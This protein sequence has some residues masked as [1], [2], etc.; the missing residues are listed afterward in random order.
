[1][2]MDSNHRCLFEILIYSQVPSVAR[3]TIQKT[4]IYKQK[5]P[6]H[7]SVPSGLP[8]LLG[9]FERSY[10]NDRSRMAS[11]DLSSKRA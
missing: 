5:S 8:V 7:L 3:P 2:V 1:M 6:E 11:F 9:R 10:I 4:K